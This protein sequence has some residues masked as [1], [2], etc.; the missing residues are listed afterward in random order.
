MLTKQAYKPILYIM[1]STKFQKLPLRNRMRLC[2]GRGACEDNVFDCVRQR[3]VTQLV[4]DTEIP[5]AVR[6]G[7]AAEQSIKPDIV[8]GFKTTE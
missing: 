3:P 6:W 4:R 7:V 2:Y 8:S 5:R 1:E